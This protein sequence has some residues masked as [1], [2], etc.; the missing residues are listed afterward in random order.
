MK[1]GRVLKRIIVAVLSMA[2][3]F[4]TLAPVSMAAGPDLVDHRPG[5]YISNRTDNPTN[6]CHF[7]Y[8]YG[9]N[10]NFYPMNYHDPNISGFRP[11]S[12]GDFEKVSSWQHFVTPQRWVAFGFKIAQSGTITGTSHTP[13]YPQWDSSQL[14]VVLKNGETGLYSPVYPTAGQWEWLDITGS[15][16]TPDIASNTPMFTTEY[17]SGDT[18]FYIVRPKGNVAQAGV[19]LDPKISMTYG[20]TTSAY[21]A[22]FTGFENR[23][24][25]ASLYP[26]VFNYD[27]SDTSYNDENRRY[28]GL[29]TIEIVEKSDGS[30]R[31]WG[32]YLTGG[33]GEDVDN[34]EMF[35][36]SDDNGVTWSDPVF[37]LEQTADP[38]KLRNG[39]AIL[40][41]EPTTQKL[42]LMW[43]QSYTW[44]D[45]RAGVWI[46]ICDNPGADDPGDMVWSTPRRIADGFINTK[47]TVLSNGKILVGMPIWSYQEFSITQNSP[48][49]EIPKRMQEARV[50]E[51]DIN[52]SYFDYIGSFAPSDTIRLFDEPMIYETQAGNPNHLTMVIR[53]KTGLYA[54]T[55]SNGGKTWTPVVST[56]NSFGFWDDEGA[57]AT[58]TR[59]YLAR[60]QSDNLLMVYHDEAAGSSRKYMTAKLSTDNGAT[61]QGGLLL[62]AG[63]TSYPDVTQGADGR[64]Y[65]IYDHEREWSKEVLV[66]SFTEADILSGSS[67]SASLN[68][69]VRKATGEPVYKEVKTF[70]HSWLFADSGFTAGSTDPTVRE[71]LGIRS[72]RYLQGQNGQC[73]PASLYDAAASTWRSSD[74]TARI[75]SWFMAATGS[76][77][78]VNAWRSPGAGN[79]SIS[80]SFSDV[81][82]TGGAGTAKMMIVQKRGNDYYPLWPTAGA[83][84]WQTITDDERVSL[85]GG[86]AAT[87]STTS[88][89]EIFIVLQ[90]GS[91]QI[92][93]NPQISFTSKEAD[94]NIVITPPNTSLFVPWPQGA[95]TPG[96]P[97]THASSWYIN[98]KTQNDAQNDYPFS[99]RQGYNGVYNIFLPTRGEL[100]SNAVWQG[101]NAAPPWIAPWFISGNTGVDG[102]VTFTASENG[103]AE[104]L[105]RQEGLTLEAV[106]AGYDG[107]SFMIVQENV[108]GQFAP[109][110]PVAG[111]WEWKT[112]SADITGDFEGFST[113]MVAGEKIHFIVHSTGIPQGD[114]LAFDPKVRYTT[115]TGSELYPA[116][117]SAFQYD[118]EP[119]NVNGDAV[120]DVVDLIRLK[121]HLANHFLAGKALAAADA[122]RDGIVGA[123]DL[124]YIRK[125]M[126]GLL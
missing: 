36:Y 39:E 100:Y 21:P 115:F 33:I 65:T 4:T 31:L 6:G 81:Y 72:Y 52:A 9:K 109:L 58:S 67:A 125:R 44:Y 56:S 119:G 61:W 13:V 7:T 11:E 93:I 80:T 64:I 102:V 14:M 63:E 49:F 16:A 38:H 30:E 41:V 8:Y 54:A 18:L 53:V 5:W 19:S 23:D 86:N 82:L 111:Q 124:I 104:I 78:M 92:S 94:K 26:P 66:S 57:N 97:V 77:D 62:N 106:A 70:N 45:G 116:S 107:L 15:N 50:Y 69:L 99:Y 68:N 10:G 79:V 101:A 83:F 76:Q 98:N 12:A 48:N 122:N 89:D 3:L 55:S 20:N 112:V 95:V 37:T 87:T 88:G 34:Y 121:K 90:K 17:K 91:Q 118:S 51:T 59:F 24:F 1:K 123:A 113:Y 47:P 75:A 117:W 22:T 46:S 110:Y 85:S 103:K 29:A 105:G 25:D 71:W 74:G 126:L 40:W 120:I 114:V 32:G 42:W 2:L 35:C 108:Q 73:G 28:Q 84:D 60:L 43:S 27:L 96:T